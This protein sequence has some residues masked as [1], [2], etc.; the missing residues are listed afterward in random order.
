MTDFFPTEFDRYLFHEGRHWQSYNILGAHLCGKDGEKG[1][2][3]TVWAPK[4]QHISVIGDFNNWDDSKHKMQKIKDSGLWTIFIPGSHQG[5]KYKYK[6][7]D[8]KNIIREKAD[9]FGFYAEKPPATASIV[10]S[11]TD[12][13]WNDRT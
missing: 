13:Q 3:F 6:I 10:Y 9:P 4:A 1:T 5:K 2:H 7:K 8:Y 11:F 12:Y